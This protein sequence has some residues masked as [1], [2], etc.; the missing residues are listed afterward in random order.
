MPHIGAGV[1]LPSIDT[2]S[3]LPMETL[4]ADVVERRGHGTEDRVVPATGTRAAD[5][6]TRSLRLIGLALTLVFLSAL[7]S[8]VSSPVE[9]RDWTPQIQ[10]TRR[11]QVYWESL[12]R[13]A[14]A[15]LRGL[16]KTKRQAQRKLRKIE[17]K[18]EAAA[19]RRASAKRRLEAIR[20]DLA[21]ARE[22]LEATTTAVEPPGPPDATAALEVLLTP[23]MS[24]LTVP[25]TALA[26][27]EPDPGP[28]IALGAVVEGAGSGEVVDRSA[29]AKLA[30]KA[31]RAK[32][33]FRQAQRQAKRAARNARAVKTRVRAVKAAE[34]GA[35]ARRERAE[36]SLGAWILAMT[37]YGRIRATKKSKTRPG[38]NSP[39]AWPV[40]GTDQPVLPCRPRR[41]RHRPLP[42]RA[43]ACRGLRCG[44]VRRLE[45]VGSARTSVHGGGYARRRF[46]DPLWPPAAEARGARW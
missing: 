9:A 15:E 46:R 23:A 4:S 6:R 24:G 12:M 36:R 27:P 41:A 29:V 22:Q 28:D 45:P 1:G 17:S 39:F 8:V 3:L 2:W 14:D 7:G 19:R 18:R 38:V 31:K 10:A 21:T 26:D 44:D 43:G 16:K 30:R 42:K 5:A 25:S 32:R 37:K 13:A 35:F 40:R 34:S 20:A 11:A 33:D